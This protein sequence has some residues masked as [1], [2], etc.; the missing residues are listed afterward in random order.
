MSELSELPISPVADAEGLLQL[1]RR[2]VYEISGDPESAAILFCE[3]PR[4]ITLGRHASRLNVRD[5]DET[6]VSKRL[7]MQWVPRGGGAMLHLPGQVTCYPIFPITAWGITPA[8]YVRALEQ[9]IADVAGFFGVAAEV[10]P[11][12]PGVR[13]GGRRVAGIG[14]AVRQGVSL[15]GFVL[16][17]DPDLEE[18]RRIDCDG[19]PQPMTSL[20]RESPH[21]IHLQSVQQRLLGAL[22]SH[23]GLRAETPF[24]HRPVTIV[25]LRR[26]AYSER[27]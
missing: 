20:Q 3:H 11:I 6:L 25:P 17:V 24:H 19:D 12:N 22:A 14:A 4:G 8:D 21:R 7:P 9:V 2:L 15:Y 18:F 1:Q 13:V 5:P 27:Y 26:H 10:D 23:F 16:N